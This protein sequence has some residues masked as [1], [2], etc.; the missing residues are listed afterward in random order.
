MAMDAV[1]NPELTA[2][3]RV[4][5]LGFAGGSMSLGTLRLLDAL[6]QRPVSWTAM[7][8]DARELRAHGAGLS[9]A[10]VRRMEADFRR[11]TVRP[12]PRWAYGAAMLTGGLVA[13]SPA[14]APSTSKKD[15]A[16]AAALGAPLLLTAGIGLVLSLA[17]PDGYRATFTGF[18][19]CN[20]PPSVQIA[21]RVY[22]PAAASE[23]C[24]HSVPPDCR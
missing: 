19:G 13:L 1:A 8:A 12:V 3:E 24:A 9:R 14:F 23:N 15:R 11:A 22:G 16:F 4:T 10:E 5:L 6:L 20:S 18:R 2:A 21:P 17:V 7:A